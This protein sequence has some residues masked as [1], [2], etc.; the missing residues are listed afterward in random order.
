MDAVKKT[1]KPRKKRVV[2][3][4]TKP[5]QKQKQKQST[6]IKIVIGDAKKKPVVRKKKSSSSQPPSPPPRQRILAQQS[7]EPQFVYAPQIPRQTPNS[8]PNILL[9]TAPAVN[10]LISQEYINDQLMARQRANMGGAVKKM[11]ELVNELDAKRR[12]VVEEPIE[13]SRAR[14]K[15]DELVRKVVAEPVA[16]IYQM[17]R[18]KSAIG[19]PVGFKDV[20]PPDITIAQAEV[21]QVIRAFKAPPMGD[22]IAEAYRQKTG[23]VFEIKKTR[24]KRRTPAEMAEDK[25]SAEEKR[26][27]RMIAKNPLLGLDMGTAFKPSATVVASQAKPPLLD[28]FRG[29]E[30]QEPVSVELMSGVKPPNSPPKPPVKVV[31]RRPKKIKVIPDDMPFGGGG[32]AEESKTFG[33]IDDRDFQDPLYV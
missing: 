32:G 24:A 16:D 12:A 23:Q 13:F 5:L 18:Q 10:P 21:P 1:K 8:Q 4:K 14:E 9:P 19:E 26:R 22:M 7:Q 11:D 17:T 6:N 27:Q 29:A 25:A 28:T 15:I 3:A 20:R 31:I 33:S 2:K 30:E